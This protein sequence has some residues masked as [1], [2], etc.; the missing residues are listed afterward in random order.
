MLAPPTTGTFDQFPSGPTPPHTPRSQ[1]VRRAGGAAGVGN[2]I[3][4]AQLLQAVVDGSID[5]M[6]FAQAVSERADDMHWLA[7]LGM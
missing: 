2:V 4:V 3:S 7:A 1:S 5:G 6:A